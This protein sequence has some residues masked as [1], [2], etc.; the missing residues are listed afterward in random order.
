[1]QC[2]QRSPQIPPSHGRITGFTGLVYAV[3]NSALKDRQGSVGVGNTYRVSSMKG[4][5][6]GERSGRSLG[7][8]GSAAISS[9]GV[10]FGRRGEL[11][12]GARVAETDFGGRTAHLRVQLQEYWYLSSDSRRWWADGPSLLCG[13]QD[14]LFNG[15]TE[16]RHRLSVGPSTQAHFLIR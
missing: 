8:A 10:G 12:S 1:M 4:W 7:G 15:P 5:D 3:P 14:W 11:K 16:T 13:A 6:S 9:R 2:Y